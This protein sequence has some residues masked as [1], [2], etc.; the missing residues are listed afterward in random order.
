MNQL[1]P[2]THELVEVVLSKMSNKQSTEIEVDEAKFSYIDCEN[3]KFAMWKD[4]RV[5]A[6]RELK[7]LKLNVWRK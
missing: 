3:V 2:K 4:F 6:C 1:S 7:H 5:E